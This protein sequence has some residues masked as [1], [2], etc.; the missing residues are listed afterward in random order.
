MPSP[1]PH[2]APF[3]P[4]AT[5]SPR[6]AATAS[7][8]LEAREYLSSCLYLTAKMPSLGRWRMELYWSVGGKCTAVSHPLE[9]TTSHSQ[10]SRAQGC[11]ET[12]GTFTIGVWMA[13]SGRTR[14]VLVFSL[15]DEHLCVY[16]SVYLLCAVCMY[17]YPHTAHKKERLVTSSSFPPPRLTACTCHRQGIPWHATHIAMA[18]HCRT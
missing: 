7:L 9:P 17:A 11:L 4:P 13:T 12:P 2:S 15:Q 14:S 5:I 8:D 10:S 1:H 3:A 18:V 16:L 6:T